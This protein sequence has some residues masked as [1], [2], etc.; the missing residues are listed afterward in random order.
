ME[1]SEAI[2]IV[3]RLYDDLK[4]EDPDQEVAGWAIPTLDAGLVAARAH[5]PKDHPVVIHVA[6]LLS[7]ANAGGIEEP[8]RAFDLRLQVGMLLEA[9]EARVPPI[10]L[11]EM[12]KSWYERDF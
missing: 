8:I 11:G 6:D 2:S 3:R 10:R 1:L 5:L 9:L 4:S 12:V 7:A